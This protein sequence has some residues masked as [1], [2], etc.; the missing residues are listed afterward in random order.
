MASLTKDEMIERYRKAYDAIPQDALELDL[1]VTVKTIQALAE[2]NP[3]SPDRLA[4]L[5][6][7]DIDQVRIILNQALAAGR[8]E[9]DDQGNLFG[10]ILSLNPTPHRI[11]IGGKELYAWCAYDAIYI[12]GV[13]G[14]SA[15]I[16]SEDPNTGGL[17]NIFITPSGVARIHPEGTVIS[18]VGPEADMRGGANSSR[19][20]QMRFFESRDSADRWV[21]GHSGISVLSVED[22]Y[23]VA[24]KLQLE[25]ARRLGLI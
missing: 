8:V 17:I 6:E 16:T 25:P 4:E 19:C 22:G 10:G 9:L 7:M 2:G 11:S 14:K 12:P 13:V 15:E 24:E 20:S 21:Q 3:V 1:R 5:W 23:E 18:V